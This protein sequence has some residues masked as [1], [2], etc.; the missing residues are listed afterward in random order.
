M[1]DGNKL[2]EITNRRKRA[3]AQ[4]LALKSKVYEGF[5]VMEQ[6]AYSSG[7]LPKKQKELIAVGISVVKDCESCMQW[8]IEQAAGA[9]ASF[10]EIFEAIEVGI[11]MGGGPA[12]VSARFALEVMEELGLKPQQK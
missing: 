2:D 4:L 3:H 1:T 5:L 8:H 11:E 6:A 7:A 10:E 12:T 9:G